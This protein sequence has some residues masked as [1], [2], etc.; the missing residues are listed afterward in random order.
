MSPYR[1][2]LGLPGLFLVLAVLFPVSLQA[3][4]TRE[5]SVKA[6][7]LYNLMLF[8][9]WPE[10]ALA[11]ARY[12]RICLLDDKGLA[13][14]LQTYE[15]R[16]VHGLP[17]QIQQSTGTPDDLRSCHAVMV[18]LGNPTALARTAIIARTQ[19]LLVV[20]EGAGVV[21]KGAM[22]GLN[23]DSGRVTF[24]IDLMA[25][26]RSHLNA[27]SKLLNLAKRVIE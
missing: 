6:A 26:R 18:E 10:S 16:K 24:D 15:G 14:A 5:T 1:P 22:V 13:S 25:L 21:D 19:P 11:E 27:S 3:Q 4:Q 20:A 9:H 7:V 12:F 17:L 8:I 23:T 2:L